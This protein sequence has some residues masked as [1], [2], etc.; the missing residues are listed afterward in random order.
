[1]TRSIRT[2]A[3]A[4]AVTFAAL[5]A[6]APPA[7]GSA[8]VQTYADTTSVGVH[9]TYEK[10]SFP[11]LAD[12]LDSG[13][14]L[15][16]LDVWTN[17]AGPGWRVAHENPVG[18]DNNCAG[19]RSPSELRGGPRDT[20]LEGCMSDLRA[21]HDANPGHRPVL[22]KVELKDG[23]TAMCGVGPH[24][25]DTASASCGR[26]PDE[27]DALVGDRLGDAV[28][29]PA[30]LVGDS[31]STLDAAVRERGWPSARATAGKFVFELIPGTVEEKNPLDDLW[32]DRHYATH[33]RDLAAEGDL[34]RAV[35]FPAVHGAEAGDPR[36]AR[37]DPTLRPWFVLFD[38][39]ASAY[40]D[41]RIDTRW[42]HDN[43]Y[44]LVMTDAHRVL[45]VIDGVHPAVRDARARVR[46]LAE[47]SASVVTADWTQ[48]PRVLSTVL[49]RG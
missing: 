32:T 40:V 31:G 28:F 35:A 48:L 4:A 33:L 26:G 1:M 20:G 9:N 7:V 24:E 38:G 11:Y 3:V 29:R 45:P 44:L 6:A 19:A 46:M 34:A 49:P 8:A 23:F 30:D 10:T 13:T 42:Y 25:F 16:E 21:W 22:V 43:G 41:G 36:V 12:A 2:N 15:I 5:T 18:N 27:F 14:A 39:D 47:R 17:S 37:Y